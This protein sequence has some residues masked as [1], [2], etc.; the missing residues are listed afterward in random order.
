MRIIFGTFFIIASILG[1]IFF[2]RYSGPAITYPVLWYIFFVLIGIIGFLLFRRS[3][4]KVERTIN[5]FE[6][7]NIEEIKKN[8]ERIE[9]DFDQC[10]FKNGGYSHEVIDENV[11]SLNW[12]SPGITYTPTK[13]ER[14]ENSTL[15]YKHTIAGNTERYI[16]SFPFDSTTLKFY[17]LNKKIKLYVSSFD[18]SKFIFEQGN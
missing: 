11:N 10:E 8:A 7:K 9:L 18:S 5:E 1:T 14:V 16:E 4:K 2:N 3:S 15:V 6:K 17:V 12:I 13:T